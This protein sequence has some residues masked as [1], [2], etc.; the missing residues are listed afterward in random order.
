MREAVG[1]TL[2]SLAE[3]AEAPE[4]AGAATAESQGLT[5]AWEIDAATHD[6]QVQPAIEMETHDL[7]G[8]G[9]EETLAIRGRYLTVIE[10]DGSVRWEFDGTDELYAV[11]AYDIDGDGGLEVFT[12]GKSKVLYVLD[13]DGTLIN[14]HPIETYW[15]VSRTTIHEPRLD[16]VVVG[17]FD[18][19]GEWEACLGTVD[20]FTQVINSDFSQRWIFGETNHGTTEIEALDVNDDGVQELV[21][22]NRYG[23]LFVLSADEGKRV[24]L[25]YSELGDVQ[26]AAGDLEG[27]GAIELVNGSATGAF[28]VG[29]VGSRDVLWEYPNYGY[30]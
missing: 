17:D 15:R 19:D 1:D 28:K 21:V 23:K 10:A 11:G 25:R 27:D 9:S 14:E 7:E 12:G 20:G 24:G 22:A 18:S 2:A 29:R 5:Q 30:A 6:E 26:M 8:D 4:G 16:D 13:T 3:R